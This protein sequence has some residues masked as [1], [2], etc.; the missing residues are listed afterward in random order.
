L[1]YSRELPDQHED[2]FFRKVAN[3]ITRLYQTTVNSSHENFGPDVSVAS[4]DEIGLLAQTINEMSTKLH[5]LQCSKEQSK[6]QLEARVRA[7]TRDLQQMCNRLKN[8][9]NTSSQGFWRVDNDMLTQEINPR[10]A[11]ILKCRQEDVIGK[12]IMGF[13]GVPNRTILH[14]KFIWGRA[15]YPL[16]MK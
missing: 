10:M 3:S 7:R 9:L 14:N 11:G 1:D 2:V 15:C 13:V 16:S 4:D 8:I 6:D 12:S 5:K